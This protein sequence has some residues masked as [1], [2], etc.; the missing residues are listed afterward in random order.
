MAELDGLER[1]PEDLV[2]RFEDPPV[3]GLARSP[4]A[5]SA[6]DIVQDRLGVDHRAARELGLLEP[7]EAGQRGRNFV[8]HAHVIVRSGS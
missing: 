1:L 7:F 3:F 2:E 6:A 5:R 4:V 8:V